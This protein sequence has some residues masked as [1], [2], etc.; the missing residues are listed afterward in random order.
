MGTRAA[1]LGAHDAHGACAFPSEPSCSP[2]FDLLKPTQGGLEPTVVLL[3]L[4]PEHWGVPVML[5][6]PC[7]LRLFSLLPCGGDLFFETETLNSWSSC[8]NAPGWDCR[9]VPALLA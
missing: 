2:S 5:A 8:L 6:L 9:P 1:D 4:F 7:I 3:L